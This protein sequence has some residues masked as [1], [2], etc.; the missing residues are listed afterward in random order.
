MVVVVTSVGIVLE[1][2][3]ENS[4]A[5]YV[6]KCLSKIGKVSVNGRPCV[7]RGVMVANLTHIYEAFPYM[8]L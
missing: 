7:K 3:G 4:F 6:A 2:R 8:P 5:L 1:T